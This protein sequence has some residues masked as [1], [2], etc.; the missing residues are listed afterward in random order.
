MKIKCNCPNCEN[1]NWFTPEKIDSPGNKISFS[2]SSEKCSSCGAEITVQSINVYMDI[3]VH[4]QPQMEEDKD[5]E[6]ES[7]RDYIEE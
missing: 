6:G 2:S 3:A 5:E 1:T 4:R 7:I